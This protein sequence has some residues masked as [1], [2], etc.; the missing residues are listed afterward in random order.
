M[1]IDRVYGLYCYADNGEMYSPFFQTRREAIEYLG[2]FQDEILEENDN[3]LEEYVQID[4][5]E[6]NLNNVDVLEQYACA[7]T[8][9]TWKQC[10]CEDFYCWHN[11]AIKSN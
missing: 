6:I 1:Q 10:E 4:L 7:N 3:A 5:L 9:S 8:I 11:F 2:F